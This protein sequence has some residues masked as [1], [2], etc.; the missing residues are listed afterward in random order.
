MKIMNLYFKGVLLFYCFFTEETGHKKKKLSGVFSFIVLVFFICFSVKYLL[1]FKF[2]YFF[3][4]YQTMNF[5]LKFQI[6]F[7]LNFNKK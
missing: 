2:F 5:S 7:I 3:F 4:C 6:F 1:K